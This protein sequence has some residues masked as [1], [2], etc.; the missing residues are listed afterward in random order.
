MTLLPLLLLAPCLA[1]SLRYREPKEA[2][3]QLESVPGSPAG[4]VD[5]LGDLTVYRYG[6]ATG[7]KWI[8]WAHDIFGVESGR[9][10]EYCALMAA[11][12][13]IT[14]I[15][16]DFFRGAPP[17][18][19]WADPVPTW[20]DLETDWEDK[21]LPYLS[22]AGAESVGVVG[23]CY[24]S[25]LGVHFSANQLVKGGIY[26]HP[27]HPGLMAGAGEDEAEAYRQ[28]SSPQAFMDT[29]DSDPSVREGGLASKIL[30]TVHSL[31]P[32]ILT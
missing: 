32:S 30:E 27:S 17:P 14:C 13:G 6:P 29:P 5:Q 26:Y 23:T 24:G 31:H 15:L 3:G 2:Y 16:P 4:E 11:Q 1:T 28:I 9:T 22:A 25:Y 19:N 18:T 12:L 10:R 21:L 8:L 20:A 7:A